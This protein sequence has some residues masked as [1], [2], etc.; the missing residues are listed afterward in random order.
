[1]RTKPL[2]AVIVSVLFA[3]PLAAQQ[4]PNGRDYQVTGRIV[5]GDRSPVPLTV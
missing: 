1:M 4:S 2:E 3:A 5:M